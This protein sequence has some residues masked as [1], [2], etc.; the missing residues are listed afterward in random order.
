MVTTG[1]EFG[2]T[3]VAQTI[4]LKINKKTF[5]HLV[6]IPYIYRVT[7]NIMKISEKNIGK[8]IALC[9]NN[10]KSIA[11]KKLGISRKTLY[12]LIHRHKLESILLE[13]NIKKDEDYINTIL[14]SIDQ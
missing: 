7:I 8:F 3:L 2:V 1:G 14:E 9:R 13:R 4:R 5:Y 10:N 12:K 6:T 11:A